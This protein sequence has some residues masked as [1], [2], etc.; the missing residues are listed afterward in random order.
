[1]PRSTST[2]ASETRKK[3]YDPVPARAALAAKFQTPEELTAY[4]ARAGRKGNEQR[5]VLSAEEKVA[6]GAA[7]E[8]LARIISR[9]LGKF[10][11][12]EDAD[13]AVRS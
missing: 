2:T 11:Y 7:Y 6:L 1:M 13:E 10:G 4:Y 8:L 5:I 3:K 12:H 9:Q